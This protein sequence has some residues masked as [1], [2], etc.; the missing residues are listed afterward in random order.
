ML[1]RLL[2]PEQYDASQNGAALDVRVTV[3]FDF[4]SAW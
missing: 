1:M 4:L 2:R 3:H